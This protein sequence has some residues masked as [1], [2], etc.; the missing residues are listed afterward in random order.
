MRSEAVAYHSDWGILSMLT[1]LSGASL[2][3]TL[4]FS[5]RRISTMSTQLSWIH[6]SSCNQLGQSLSQKH[7]QLDLVWNATQ[8]DVQPGSLNPPL[9][10]WSDNRI[11]TPKDPEA[12]KRTCAGTDILRWYRTTSTPFPASTSATSSAALTVPANT[13]VR[14]VPDAWLE[15]SL[16]A[17]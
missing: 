3:A 5:L 16:T 2:G 10:D 1:E 13:I 4:S 14:P 15:S 11:A 17:A 8:A 6:E 9:H 7:A 12:G